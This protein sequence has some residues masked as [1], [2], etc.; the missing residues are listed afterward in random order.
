MTTLSQRISSRLAADIINGAL[1]P[2]AK[3]DEISLAA[4]FKVS[5]SPIRDALR[6]LAATRLVEFQPRRGFSVS[7]I[8]I[9]GL[10]DLFEAASEVE[11]LLARLCANRAG[12]AER[13]QIELLHREARRMALDGDFESYARLNEG[14]HMAIYAAARNRTLEEV[15]TSLRQRLAPFR[16]QVF[17]HVENRARA[18]VEEHESLAR[19]IVRG[20]ADAA[21]EA[22]RHHAASS[23]SNVIDY[24]AD[25]GATAR[26]AA[27][28]KGARVAA[29]GRKAATGRASSAKPAAKRV[30]TKK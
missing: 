5:R 24:F 17:F 25:A 27:P 10:L 2:G 22:M 16:S 1:G 12:L 18:S 13:K 28:P 19:A 9:A 29:A 21:C 26:L 14:F 23:A 15:A 7:A 30:Y 20:N 8:D 4:R 11:G 6:H 3:L